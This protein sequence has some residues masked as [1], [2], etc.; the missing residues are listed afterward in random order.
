MNIHRRTHDGAHQ[1][2]HWKGTYG[3]SLFDDLWEGFD[4]FPSFS[5]FG[6]SGNLDGFDG[7]HF[8]DFQSNPA[9]MY[10]KQTNQGG[11]V[12]RAINS[13]ELNWMDEYIV[14]REVEKS[15][16]GKL[17]SSF[18]KKELIFVGRDKVCFLCMRLN[19]LNCLIIILFNEK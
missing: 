8:G 17:D 11:V 10:M 6:S 1:K 9:S 13:T 15:Y 4:M 2:A 7:I 3:H 18:S 14:Y 12:L 5:G 16:P 19:I